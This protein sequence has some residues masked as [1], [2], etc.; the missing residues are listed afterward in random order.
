MGRY[1]TFQHI[2]QL[3][4]ERDAIEICHLLAGYEFPWDI[5]RALELALLRTFCIPSI[6][7][8]LDRT[9]EFH[10]HTQKRYDDT[11]IIVSELFKWGYED[12]RGQAFLQRMN[13]IHSRF[14]IRN[15][16]YLYVLST[17]VYE[18]IRWCDRNGW[19][20]FCEIEK[21]ATYHFWRAVGSR[22]GIENIPETYEAFEGYNQTYEI[23]HFRYAETNQRVADA[24][25]A[26]MLGWFPSGLR[27][28]VNLG[29]PTILDTPLLTA[30]GWEPAAPAL[31][32]LVQNTLKFRSRL[33]RKLPPRST[34]D[35]F[36]DQKIRSYP[37]GYGVKD[38]G[39]PG[40][41]GKL[42]RGDG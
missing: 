40:L 27:A 33:L 17:F 7:A 4:P 23:Q 12:P 25:R 9:G 14:A 6:S 2:Q 1:T 35:F 34:T 10:H 20:P 41:L 39:P 38:I 26:M 15:E 18:P 36:A 5:T 30:L 37:Q 24:T 11:G 16:D 8:L 21:Q 13:A 19:R 29:I 31:Q 28:G 22:M 3:D 32:R 42:N